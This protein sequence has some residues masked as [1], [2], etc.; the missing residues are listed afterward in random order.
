[1][2]LSSKINHIL[3]K[4][5]R[6]IDFLDVSND[7]EEMTYKLARII[8]RI[9]TILKEP[10]ITLSDENRHI[11]LASQK[12]LRQLKKTL[13]GDLSPES[14]LSALNV[15]RK[16]RALMKG[17][18]VV[19]SERD[20]RDQNSNLGSAYREIFEPWID[21]ET[22]QV[23]L[24]EDTEVASACGTILL[25]PN[26]DQDAL[27]AANDILESCT[28]H[29]N[30][31]VL[32][33]EQNLH[34]TI[35]EVDVFLS[36]ERGAKKRDK[37]I[38]KTSARYFTPSIEE[39]EKLK[40]KIEKSVSCRTLSA[41]ED[42]KNNLEGLNSREIILTMLRAIQ[43]LKTEKR[44]VSTKPAEEYLCFSADQAVR[45]SHMSS[46]SNLS[47]VFV[48]S[49]GCYGRLKKNGKEDAM[50]VL[51][52]FETIEERCGKDKLMQI[53]FEF[54]KNPAAITLAF[55]GLS[56]NEKNRTLLRGLTRALTFV[57]QA[58]IWRYLPLDL[59]GAQERCEPVRNISFAMGLAEGIELLEVDRVE[60]ADLFDA[61]AE[62]GLP[63]GQ[64]ILHSFDHIRAKKQKL[65]NLVRQNLAE[66]DSALTEAIK[67]FPNAELVPSKSL[68][69]EKLR[70]TFG[71]R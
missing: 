26:S 21:P 31:L 10:S 45:V 46:S 41:V 61:D 25:N 7:N 34:T 12:Q 65:Q 42:K 71:H 6:A 9:T 17:L 54:S 50:A 18:L 40:P 8:A 67:A 1:M 51:S 2:T 14:E 66:N 57:F 68:Y 60:L 13:I 58:E 19:V 47:N 4:L 22:G 20:F 27:T 70:R 53:M 64:Q 3:T 33:H 37:R 59:V 44:V 56:Q 16:T 30:R 63:S 43:K 36:S 5:T 69:T 52:L 24:E 35:D 11:F 49:L 29:L 23:V 15:L 39:V 62:L 32:S 38:Q 48:N 55:C 28:V